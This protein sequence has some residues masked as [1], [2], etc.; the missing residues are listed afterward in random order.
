MPSRWEG[1]GLVAIEAMRNSKAV[2]VSNRG[3]LPELIDNGINGYVF[4]LDDNNSLRDILS[5]LN[6]DELEKMGLEGRKKYLEKFTDEI[7]VKNMWQIYI[8]LW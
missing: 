2:I 6:K 1:V 3:A 7:F 4:D 8:N 5:T